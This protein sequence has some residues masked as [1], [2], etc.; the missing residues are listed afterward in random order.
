MTYVV[1]RDIIYYYS[2]MLPA[3]FP[4]STLHINCVAFIDSSNS[5]FLTIAMGENLISTVLRA[6]RQDIVRY[7][8]FIG[9]ALLSILVINYFRNP[10]RHVPGPFWAKFSNL[11][12]VYHTRQGKMHRKIIEVHE[13]YGPLVRLG[14]HEISTADID[15]LRIVY[16]S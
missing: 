14:P 4:L 6:D 3:L 5:P 8:P 13:K 16:G 10:L 2:D 1:P 11:W 15:S 9:I 7:A 12:L